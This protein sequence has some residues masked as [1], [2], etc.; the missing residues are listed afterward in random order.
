MKI[1]DG[2]HPFFRPLWRRVVVTAICGAWTIVELVS[3]NTFWAGV[4]GV[5]TAL[6]VWEFFVAFKGDDRDGGPDK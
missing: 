5:M 6:C 2:Q 4:F 3:G 1:L